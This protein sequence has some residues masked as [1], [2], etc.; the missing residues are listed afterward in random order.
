MNA[1]DFE[2]LGLFYLGRPV[3]PDT[4]TRADTPFLLDAQDLTTHALCLGMTGSGKTGLGIG[5]LEEAAIDGIPAI[6]VDP[7]GDLGNLL[8]QF[9]ELRP[10]DFG[11]WIDPDQAR[12]EGVTP[13]ELA[14]TTASTWS[15]GL[16]KWGQDGDRIR[17][18]AAAADF[19]IYTPGSPAGLQLSIFSAL[20]APPPA[21]RLD[22]NT[23]RDSVTAAVSSL[24]ALANLSTDAQSPAFILLS[25]LVD[26]EWR[27]GRS[28]RLDSLIRLVQD[29]P[30]DRIGVLT[31]D[32]V[33]TPKERQSL[34]KKLN[35]LLASPSLAAWNQG[36][37]LDIQR[38]LYTA[39]G[40]PRLSVISIAHLAET[41]RMF[42]T[43]LL[44]TSIVAWMRQQPGTSSLRALFYMDEIFGYF[45]PTANPPSKAPMLTLLKQARAF[46]LGIVLATQNPV[47]IDYRGLS[48]IGLWMIGRLQTERDKK[49]L[50]DGLIGADAV[51]GLDRD[52]LSTRLSA[53]RKREFLVRNV[54]SSQIQLIESRWCLSYLRGPLSLP[55]ISTLMAP[56]KAAEGA[57]SAPAASAAAAAPAL[58]AVPATFVATADDTPSAPPMILPPEIEQRYFPVAEGDLAATA[59]HYVPH[60]LIQARIH[61]ADARKA[62]D[63]WR[64]TLHVIPVSPVTGDPDWSEM[65]LVEADGTPSPAPRATYDTL[66]SPLA[67]PKTYPRVARDFKTHRALWAGLSLPSVPSLK[68]YARPDESEGD[69]RARIDFALRE[70]TDEAKQKLETR[71]AP[72][73]ASL[74]E[75]IRKAEAKIET[76]KAQHSSS[77]LNSFLRIG[78]AI[79]SVFFGR[80]SSGVT[81]AA[82][83]IN[84]M[85]RSS[86]KKLDVQHAE[87]SLEAL[88]QQKAELDAKIAAD[89]EALAA[90]YSAEAHPVVPITLE[91]KTTD[92][93]I[94]RVLLAW[95]P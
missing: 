76:E 8:L 48:N 12:R 51:D 45:P 20:D 86:K 72:K 1:N 15:S 17:R 6:I 7:K 21:V 35:A 4:G 24:L 70:A 65:S 33:I 23:L 94:Q 28:L 63:Y 5:L 68:L 90:Q 47:D 92:I 31:L 60:L 89:L 58:S 30:T 46:G 26:R 71:Y 36:E 75:K 81:R 38:L 2:K 73:I 67:D 44:L 41:E 64:T 19:A 39:D 22:P 56:R 25:T 49:R 79:A 84:A 57:D 42:F 9:P 55:E 27:A 10:S 61:Y 16:A 54:H 69:F 34:G 77:R 14:A 11:P 13:E 50:L 66:P 29:P 37:P 85:T 3:D 78:T 59:P 40:K 95:V 87:E 18:L 43:T 83:G 74:D 80:A 32:A 62:I 91:P 88:T 52:E 82:T 93:I 53:L